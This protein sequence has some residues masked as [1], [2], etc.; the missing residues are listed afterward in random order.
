M[1]P[2]F[3]VKTHELGGMLH[4]YMAEQPTQFARY[5]TTAARMVLALTAVVAVAFVA[6]T[7]SPL[8]SGYADKPS[9]G[10]SDIDL[11]RAEVQRMWRGANYYDA[12]NAELRACG[13]P[14]GSVFNWRSPLPMWLLGNLPNFNYGKVLLCGLAA[15][16]FFQSFRLLSLERRLKGLAIGLLLLTGALLPCCLGEL[17]VLSELWA[18]VL[19][20][21]SAT[22]HG[23]GNNRVAAAWATLATVVRELALPVLC[24]GLA[25]QLLHRRWRQAIPWAFGLL[26][27]AGFYA[28]HLS[29]VSGYIQAGDRLHEH[30]WLRLGGAPFVISLAQMNA[31]LLLLPQWLTA[32]FL[33]LSVLGFASW[34]SSRGQFAG[35][36]VAAYVAVFAVIGQPFNQYWGSL[37]APLFCLGLAQ[38]PAALRDLYQ[39][40]RVTSD[41]ANSDERRVAP[42]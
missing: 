21:L 19:I 15:W 23:H 18:G 41:V 37:L 42:Q 35:L 17:C 40:A 11:Y 36:V 31:Y 5:S 2:V 33:V 26:L 20:A 39:A 29:Q 4:Y 38:A 27:F 34:S 32:L 12:A 7:L 24:I 28:W 13:Y 16:L 14:T 3:P 10:A 6:I 25:I 9:R 30:S 1:E 22:A 8:A